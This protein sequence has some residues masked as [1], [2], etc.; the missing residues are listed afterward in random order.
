MTSLM[1]HVR[2]NAVAY[3]ALFVALGGTSIAA[4]QLAARSVGTR[5]LKSNA[6]I[7]S[8]VK[9]GSLRAA[10]FRSGDLPR[11][12]AGPQG[13]TGPAGPA[14]AAAS[15][16]WAIV[17]ADGTLVRGN[18]VVSVSR[19]GV[20]QYAVQFNR[21]VS[22]CA[23]SVQLGGYTLGGEIVSPSAGE[24][25]AGTVN[26]LGTEAGNQTVNVNTR[27]SDGTQADRTFHV[28]VFC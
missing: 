14:G 10:D 9:N 19:A 24:A 4:T 8:K 5:E 13:A 1:H 25:G 11:G 28:V 21:N 16:L 3:V 12:A 27:A 7:S 17:R 15:S 2:S 22:G 18:G 20:G 6:V 23:D 26:A